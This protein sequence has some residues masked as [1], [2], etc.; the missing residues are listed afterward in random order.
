MSI[1]TRHASS[2]RPRKKFDPPGRRLRTV[3]AFLFQTRKFF[4]ALGVRPGLWRVPNGLFF[5]YPFGAALRPCRNFVPTCGSTTLDSSM[6]SQQLVS[7]TSPVRT[8][9]HCWQSRRHQPP[10]SSSLEPGSP[11]RCAAAAAGATSIGWLT[12]CCKHCDDRS[13]GNSDSLSRRWACRH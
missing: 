6:P 5:F 11:L 4:G 7:P 3:V 13:F 2:A 9:E 1:P 10:A 12:N 8:L